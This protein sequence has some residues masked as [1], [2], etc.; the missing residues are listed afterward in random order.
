MVVPLASLVT[1]NE[2]AGPDE[3]NRFDRMRSITVEAAL[4]DGVSLGDAVTELGERARARSPHYV[5]G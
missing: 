2:V 1:L 4:A 5:A 3:L